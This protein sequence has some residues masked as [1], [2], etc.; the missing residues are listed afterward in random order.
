MSANHYTIVCE[1]R[2]GTYVSQVQATDE[3]AAVRVWADKVSKERPI[4]RS[5]S[6]VATAV[7]HHLHE[8]GLSALTGLKN[9][10]CFGGEVG[11]SSILGDIILSR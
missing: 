3:I 4:P 11:A 9:V 1:F 5:S 7:L 8:Y 6:Y 2:G 10:W